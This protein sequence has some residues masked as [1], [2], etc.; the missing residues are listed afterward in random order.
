MADD[1]AEETRHAISPG[2]GDSGS[3][4][5]SIS[6]TRDLV[7]A[8]AVAWRAE[9]PFRDGQAERRLLTLLAQ[10]PSAA[11]AA[12]TSFGHDERAGKSAP[13]NH[14]SVPE[15][16]A[17]PREDEQNMPAGTEHPEGLN[18][19]NMP[20]QGE[21]MA[22]PSAASRSVRW[23]SRRA[24]A[25]T[26]AA[27][28]LAAVVLLTF[29]FGVRL[30]VRTTPNTGLFLPPPLPLH[31]SSAAAEG[32][33]SAEQAFARGAT[34]TP[35]MLEN[36][37]NSAVTSGKVAV[38]ASALDTIWLENGPNY[39]IALIQFTCPLGTR[40]HGQ[41]TFWVD[42]L[43]KRPNG[44]WLPLA[45]EYTPRPASSGMPSTQSL[46]AAVPAW[47]A[48]PGDNY[49]GHLVGPCGQI[50]PVAW[51]AWYSA[52]RTFVAGHVADRAL[53]PADARLVTI[54]GKAGW[55]AQQ[56]GMVS[57]VVPL[58]DGTTFFFAGSVTSAQVEGL[59]AQALAHLS[60]L[61]P[62]IYTGM[63]VSACN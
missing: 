24:R 2:D 3:G 45:G 6:A 30:R 48:L 37:S 21:R 51:Q 14:A 52:T 56:Y 41:S 29:I 32:S 28:G 11:G 42:S 46:S 25:F 44:E 23:T 40:E 43:G 10:W 55:M 60:A 31:W 17:A 16:S 53:M 26:I 7:M 13:S 12:Y 38:A 19:P 18:M 1:R 47:L 36:A 58:A 61:L 34:L 5:G 20:I 35:C 22:S 9:L 62:A 15:V 27:A 50:P 54:A 4:P 8:D 39:G 33:T 49:E 63:A 57:V 59:S